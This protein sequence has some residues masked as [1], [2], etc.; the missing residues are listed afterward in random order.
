M[1][2]AKI[3]IKSLEPGIYDYHDDD[4][5]RGSVIVTENARCLVFHDGK[6]NKDIQLKDQVKNFLKRPSIKVVNYK[7]FSLVN[8]QN[9]RA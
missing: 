5:K 4:F 1:G 7:P 9:T 8:Y 6:R 2:R 3:D